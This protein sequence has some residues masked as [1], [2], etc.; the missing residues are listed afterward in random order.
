ML[1][2][3]RSVAGDEELPELERYGLP[4][5]DEPLVVVVVRVTGPKS[6]RSMCAFFTPTSS[7]TMRF[8]AFALAQPLYF[9]RKS[10]I[11]DRFAGSSPQVMDF[12]L[13][14]VER[15]PEIPSILMFGFAFCTMLAMI[16][17]GTAVP[18]TTWRTSK[19]ATIT[20]T[21]RATRIT[22]QP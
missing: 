4:A 10:R 22:R 14:P 7:I 3:P 11:S 13:G 17:N 6:A 1:S 19:K 16:R 12:T 15:S 18:T 8:V 21:I 20:S 2:I 9:T 5:D